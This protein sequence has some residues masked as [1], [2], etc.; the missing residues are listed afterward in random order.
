MKMLMT[1][2][3]V[4]VFLFAGI[5]NTM[6]TQSSGDQIPIETTPYTNS[7]EA[8]TTIPINMTTTSV[9][10][11]QNITTLTVFLTLTVTQTHV[12]IQTVS[13]I[14]VVTVGIGLNANQAMVIITIIAIIT[15]SVGYFIGYKTA[16]GRYAHAKEVTQKPKRR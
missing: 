3:A 15:V 9:D 12:V 7:R 4:F 11:N 1:I 13:E 8:D 6:L 16:E 14:S 2:A 5:S 10:E